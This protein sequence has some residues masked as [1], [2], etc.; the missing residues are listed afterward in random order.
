MESEA[1]G[2]SGK[3]KYFEF[4]PN[5]FNKNI[6]DIDPFQLRDELFSSRLD[7]N[8]WALVENLLLVIEDEAKKV[9]D[10]MPNVEGSEW[11]FWSR[12][13]NLELKPRHANAVA[14]LRSIAI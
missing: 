9:L 13:G 12:Y 6:L 7:E 8:A 10:D 4:F 11:D 1:N 2:R 14:A 5:F 3:A